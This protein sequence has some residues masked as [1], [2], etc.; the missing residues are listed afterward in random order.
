MSL[1]FILKG[2]PRLSETFIAQEIAG[3]EERGYP[4][5]I[6]SLR[7]PTDQLTHPVHQRIQ[8]PILYLPEYFYQEPRRCLKAFFHCFCNYSLKNVM[9]AW[10]QDFCRDRSVN[11][12]RRLIQ[13]MV[14]ACELPTHIHHL[15][16]HF[17]HSPASVSVYTSL[18][19]KLPFSGSAHAKDI[20]TSPVWDIKNKIEKS[21]FI[22]VC[23]QAGEY[24][25]R[26][27]SDQQD[28]IKLIYHGID[29]K[30]VSVK[31]TAKP[32]QNLSHTPFQIISVGR[33][34]AKKGYDHVLQ[35]LAL[36]D[37]EWQFIHIG[38]GSNK[39]LKQQAQTLGISPHIVWKGSLSRPDI[40]HLMRQS[41]LFI[42]ASKIVENGDR[43]GLPNVLMEAA[44]QK[45]AM[46]ASDV[47]A[48][49]ELIEDQKT[50]LLVEPQNPQQLADA[51]T[52]L[53]A[54]PVLRF[55]L[56]EQAYDLLST[57][58]DHQCW[59]DRLEQIFK[60]KHII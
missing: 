6:V 18:I 23:T 55:K 48:I 59:L 8:A 50:G 22:C 20:W 41:D 21:S 53:H 36:L 39:T 44:G 1:A 11:R 34:V 3:F 47:S 30:E 38:P 26:N 27:M 7:K 13:A 52:H 12:M 2:Y 46:V 43:D 29:L 25:L 15:H 32:A 56:A 9:R 5:L 4:L 54:N 58:F 17:M 10:F 60:L 24:A 45:L 19:K 57:K 42:L 37:F 51:I 33:I 35:A 14:L 16:F 31:K 40:L 49:P 28:K